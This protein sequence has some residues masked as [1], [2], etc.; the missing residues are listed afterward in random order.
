MMAS[1]KIIDLHPEMQPLAEKFLDA[2][3]AAGIEVLVTCTYRSM[4]EQAALYAQGR[5]SAGHVVTNARPG[6]SRHNDLLNGKPAA[7]AFDIVPMRA[8]KPVWDAED[9]VW[10][11]MGDIG[12]SL[13]LEWAGRWIH[14]R[15]F[16]HFQLPKTEAA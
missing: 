4:A 7:R 11:Q 13:G 3:H 14:F 12:E 5:T 9:P 10:Q 8:G 1:R 6:E 2:C 16:P 15:E